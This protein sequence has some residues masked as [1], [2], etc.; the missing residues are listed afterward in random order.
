MPVATSKVL[1]SFSASL[2]LC[3]IPFPFGRGHA[4][5]FILAQR[6]RG[7]EKYIFLKR[8]VL[9][10]AFQQMR[11]TVMPVAT[12]KVLVFFS[13]SLRLCA[14][15]FPFGSGHAGLFILAQRRRGAEKYIF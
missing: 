3:A 6:R 1:V 4:G 7:A 5:L 12:N 13:A 9:V 15:P 14:I 8:D 2:R 10:Y 11:R